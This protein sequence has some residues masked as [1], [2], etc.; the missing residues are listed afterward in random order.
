MPRISKLTAEQLD[1]LRADLSTYIDR[2]S[3]KQLG[4]K[5][6]ITPASVCYYK[7]K[8]IISVTSI[9]IGKLYEKPK[10]QHKSYEEHL[11]DY[12]KKIGKPYKVPPVLRPGG[13]FLDW[14]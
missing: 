14:L 13:T 12:Y 7:K 1:E 11:R 8:F 2:Q 4:I 5:F 10:P 3:Y 6:Q 9:R